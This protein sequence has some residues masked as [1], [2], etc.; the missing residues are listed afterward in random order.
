MY[1]VGH[2]E[3][4][5]ASIFA[6]LG[7]KLHGIVESVRLLLPQQHCNLQF[8]DICEIPVTERVGK[9][10]DLKQFIPCVF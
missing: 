7:S 1:L 6:M 10:M 2:Y 8:L 5:A 4:I 9:E 3:V